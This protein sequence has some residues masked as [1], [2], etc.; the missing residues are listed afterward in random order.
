[1]SVREHHTSV[2]RRL[3]PTFQVRA[4]ETGGRLREVLAIGQSAANTLSFGTR[5]TRPARPVSTFRPA[6]GTGG[7]AEGNGEGSSNGEDFRFEDYP[8]DAFAPR[9]QGALD[10][11]H[12]L[13]QLHPNRDVRDLTNLMGNSEVSNE[14]RPPTVTRQ[15]PHYGQPRAPLPGG[16]APPPGGQAPLPGGQAPLPGW[17]PSRGSPLRSPSRS[18]SR[19]PSRMDT[20]R[21]DTSRMNPRSRGRRRTNSSPPDASDS[22]EEQAASELAAM[23]RRPA[24]PWWA[25]DRSARG[26]P[27]SMPP[28]SAN[29][30]PN[31]PS[32]RGSPSGIEN[33][34]MPPN[35]GPVAEP[36]VQPPSNAGPSGTVHDND[37]DRGMRY[38][39]PDLPEDYGAGMRYYPPE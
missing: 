39:P 11:P 3:P 8:R 17:S 31:V 18:R 28:G 26:G 32:G 2:L 23:R 38:Y 10:P 36:A 15:G 29:A 20:S 7:N 12:W 37:G 21:M 34:L 35:A 6:A 5:A 22:D 30:N 1:M 16:Q 25:L 19:S 14:L 27:A 4:P 9:R 13:Q 33:D 24:M